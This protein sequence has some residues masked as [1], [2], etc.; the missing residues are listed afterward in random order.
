MG[1]QPATPERSSSHW[2][3][4]VTSSL[5]QPAPF[6]AG[7]AEPLMEGFVLSML[8]PLTVVD[9]LLSATSTAVPLAD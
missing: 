6:G 8:M 5:F 3:E 7:E 4:T 1:P 2:N 9:A